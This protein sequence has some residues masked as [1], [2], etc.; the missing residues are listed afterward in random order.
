MSFR[1]RSQDFS[2]DELNYV[3]DVKT[4]STSICL[5]IAVS[6][7]NDSLCFSTFQNQSDNSLSELLWNNS[8]RDCNWSCSELT[9][10]SETFSTSRVCGSETISQTFMS[11][12]VVSYRI[13]SSHHTSVLRATREVN[14]RRQIYP[15]HHNHSPTPL[16]RQSPNIAHVIMST[17][18]AHTPHLVE[19]APGPGVTSP[20]IAKVTTHFL[21]LGTQN[22]L[23]T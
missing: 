7:D 14:G 4:H 12:G 3:V 2:I 20:H 16:N 13:V 6:F 19:I 21:F 22:F 1:T 23:P 17:I 18:S 5:I 8:L 10:V 15:S 9:S 11:Y